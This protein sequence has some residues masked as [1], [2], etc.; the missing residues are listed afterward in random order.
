MENT[1]AEDTLP[2]VSQPQAAWLTYHT[3]SFYALLQV[4]INHF[5]CLNERWTVSKH[6]ILF[7][8]YCW[9]NYGLAF[10]VDLQI[11]NTD[12]WTE[13]SDLKIP[14]PWNNVQMLSFWIICVLM[15]AVPLLPSQR[16]RQ[17][18]NMH[19]WWEVEVG[20]IYSKLLGPFTLAKNSR[21]RKGW[22]VYICPPWGHLHL[23]KITGW[24]QD[25]VFTPVHPG[26][27]VSF[28]SRVS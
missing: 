10:S 24:A 14:L 17:G 1:K 7:H 28:S 19:T 23:Q 15:H 2:V 25:R 4:K 18:K 3:Q 22:C 8:D 5:K 6:C 11:R 27:E 9:L 21:V 26:M 12:F 16:L 20:G 13:Y